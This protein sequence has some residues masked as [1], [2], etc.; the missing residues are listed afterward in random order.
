MNYPG[1]RQCCR[2]HRPDLAARAR[3]PPVT[4]TVER[5]RP[6][7]VAALMPNSPDALSS[8]RPDRAW[9]RPCAH[10]RFV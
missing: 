7:R 5:Q 9:F 6:Y 1:Q 3:W 8:R 4:G 2:S 10:R